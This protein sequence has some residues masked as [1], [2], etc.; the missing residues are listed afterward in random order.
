VPSDLNSDEFYSRRKES[1]DERLKMIVQ[2]FDAALGLAEEVWRTYAPTETLSLVSW[3][4]FTEFEHVAVSS[5]YSELA[6]SFAMGRVLF[7]MLNSTANPNC[8]V[9]NLTYSHT[10][11]GLGST[12]A[13]LGYNLT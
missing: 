13:R 8:T 12:W 5:L 7:F 9:C 6:K 2:D 1:V 4:Q 11:V 3:S 10:A